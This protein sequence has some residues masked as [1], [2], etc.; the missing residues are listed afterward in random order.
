MAHY[1]LWLLLSPIVQIYRFII[2]YSEDCEIVL[3]KVNEVDVILQHCLNQGWR[4]TGKDSVAREM[5]FQLN[6]PLSDN[7]L[8]TSNNT[9]RTTGISISVTSLAALQCLL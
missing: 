5:S 7:C 6:T 1:R 2:G 9:A 3:W 8:W 4:M